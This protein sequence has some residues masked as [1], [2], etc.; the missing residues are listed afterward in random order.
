MSHDHAPNKEAIAMLERAVNLDPTYAPAWE[1]L[2]TRYYYDS[3]FG[4]GGEESLKG[5]QR[6]TA[7]YEKALTLD[8]N[9]I[10]ASGQLITSRVERGELVK[11]YTDALAL[12]DKR[13]Q[14]AIAHF[15]LAYVYRYAGMLQESTHECD[16]A[17]H[18][19]PGNYAFRSC[20]WGF[21]YLGETARARDFVRLDAGSEWVNYVMPS[22][23]L[24]EGKLQ[25]AREAV[26]KMPLEPRYRRSLAEACL[27]L[28]PRSELDRM[29]QATL[30]AQDMEGDPERL[31]YLGTI[32]A[33]A[34]ENDV[35]LQMIRKA[36]ER[37]Y[38]SYSGLQ[39]DPLLGTLRRGPGFAD[40]LK[41]AQ[42]CQE[43]IIALQK[44]R[45]L[46]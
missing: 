40:L 26:K 17:L 29:A 24:R 7:A 35:A 37:N 25:Q 14:S 34:G 4:A 22:V 38:C 19:D 31:Y 32:L 15:S 18:L 33:Y 6:S 39:N 36:I 12:V 1:A 28:A 27:G 10:F 46:N 23:L 8:P 21:L 9:L 16:T 3:S 20:A 45:G 13:P 5:F 30:N 2:G 44:S 43:P 42:F 11:A 41:A